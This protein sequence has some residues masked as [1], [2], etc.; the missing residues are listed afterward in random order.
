MCMA[1]PQNMHKV[2]CSRAPEIP[3]YDWTNLIERHCPYIEWYKRVR[4]IKKRQLFRTAMKSEA[5]AK[6]LDIGM[7]PASSLAEHRLPRDRGTCCEVKNKRAILHRSIWRVRL[8]YFWYWESFGKSFKSFKTLKMAFKSQLNF[9]AWD[10]RTAWIPT[11][12]GSSDG[13]ASA[14]FLHL[15]FYAWLAHRPFLRIA[16]SWNILTGP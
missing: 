4:E 16:N 2:F 6:C 5:V 13:F 11:T 10:S 3:Q 9:L 7:L 12:R 14:F 8:Q 1:S 15:S